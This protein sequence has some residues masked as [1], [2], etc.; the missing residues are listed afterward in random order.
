MPNQDQISPNQQDRVLAREIGE[1]LPKVGKLSEL[2]DPL[3]NAL[4]SFKKDKNEVKAPVPSN[5]IWASIQADIDSLPKKP[6]TIRTLY[7]AFK[8]LAVAASIVILA[9]ASFWVYQ[10]NRGEV[11]I[12]E[13]FASTELVELQDG[14]VVTLRPHSKLYETSISEENHNYRLAGEA[15]FEVHSDPQR[16]FSVTTSQSKVEV[17]GT[18]FVLSDWGN[19][20]EVFLEEGR[21]RFTSTSTQKFIELSKGEAS[22]VSTSNPI[23]EIKAT[24][25]AEYK[26][27]LSNE[28]VFR[29]KSAQAVFSELEQH[30]N[31]SI[32]AETPLDEEDLSGTIQLDNLQSVLQNLELVLNGDFTQT[33]E[34]SYVF[35]GNE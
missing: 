29:N 22:S 21:V 12:G 9:L 19:S 28:L 25:A 11:L 33:G 1:A 31:I 32:E 14:T 8:R 34:R 18:K 35:R 16:I 5:K 17:L 20:S 13:S 2:N 4:L 30:F 3:L 27:W 24:D 26:D 7:P 15:Y 6:A 23:P 10:V